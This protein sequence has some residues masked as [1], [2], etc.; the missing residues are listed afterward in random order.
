MGYYTHYTLE[1][2]KIKDKNEYEAIIE[3][4]KEDHIYG[5]SSLFGESGVFSDSEYS[6][7]E[8]T[9]YSDEEVKWYD[10]TSDMERISLVFPN[11]IFMLHGEGEDRDDMWNKFYYNGKSETCQAQISYPQPTIVNW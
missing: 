1:V 3:E 8:A 9:F 11:V 6:F 5:D 2:R 7:H 10:H 4:L